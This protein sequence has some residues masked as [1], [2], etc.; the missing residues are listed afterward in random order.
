MDTFFNK[1]VPDNMP[2]LAATIG[3][4]DG[5]HRGHRLVVDNLRQAAS[6]RGL[7]TAVF[8]FPNHPQL[9]FHPDCGLRLLTSPEKK[10]SLLAQTGVDYTF[11]LSFTHELA[12]MTAR[13][14]MTLLHSRYN[15]RLLAV[16]YDHRFGRRS[17]ETFADYQR[18]GEAIGMDVITTPELSGD[19]HISSS[20]IRRRLAEGDVKGAASML[21]HRYCIAGKVV[22]GKRN[23][24][25]I[26]FPTANIDLDGIPLLVPPDG[27]YAVKVS[28]DGATFGGMLNIGT[29]TVDHATQ[30]TIEVNIFNFDN[31]IYG[32]TVNLEFVD[33]VRDER[34]MNGL[35]DLDRKSTRLN[36]SHRT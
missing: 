29:P 25:L 10:A 13:E 21:G 8:T 31:E 11:F 23:G 5:V 34:R 17:D 15:V 26:G 3:M 12:A 6:A 28:V 9:L 24:R 35:D 33:R 4:F 16:G 14:F 19:G 18:Y 22:D 7:K 27:V 20:A 1:Q 36:S 30:R 32:K 2:P